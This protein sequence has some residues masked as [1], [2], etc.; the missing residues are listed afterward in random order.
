MDL[1]WIWTWAWQKASFWQ[2]FC[3]LEYSPMPDVPRLGPDICVRPRGHTDVVYF[4]RQPLLSPR[5]MVA[6][7]VNLIQLETSASAVQVGR[8]S[9]KSKGKLKILLVKHL[10]RAVHLS[11]W[12]FRTVWE[13][14]FVRPWKERK[15]CEPSIKV[16]FAF[17]TQNIQK[18]NFWRT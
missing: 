2:P 7:V 11:K 10:L 18:F 16:C 12:G 14:L 5:V 6:C 4:V 9:W 17:L 15:V 3:T 1:D 8:K 13:L